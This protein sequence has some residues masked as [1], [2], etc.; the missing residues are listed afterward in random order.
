MEQLVSVTMDIQWIQMETVSYKPVTSH[1]QLVQEMHQINVH[2]ARASHPSI[3][4]SVHAQVVTTWITLDLV[5][6]AIQTAPHV[7]EDLIINAYLVRVMESSTTVHVPAP[8]DFSW[9]E[10]ETVKAVTTLVTDA[11]THLT[12]DVLHANQ[13]LLL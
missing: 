13:T 7:T 3:M 12:T 5:L 4:E 9:T 1:A 2:H 11:V 6:H 8:T 10:T